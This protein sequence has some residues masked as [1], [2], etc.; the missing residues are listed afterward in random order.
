MR[1]ILI[2][3][4]VVFFG[5]LVY[6]I[7]RIHDNAVGYGHELKMNDR[8]F[9]HL[10]DVDITAETFTD[11]DQIGELQNQIDELKKE[12]EKLKDDCGCK[13]ERD[14]RVLAKPFINTQELGGMP[15]Q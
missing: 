12:L 8:L 6:A 3:L 4:L 13:T 1:L 7:G 10:H 14:L 9:S 5:I 11:P 15:M 2:V